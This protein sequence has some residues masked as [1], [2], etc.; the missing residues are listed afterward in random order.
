[1]V[2]KPSEWTYNNMLSKLGDPAYHDPKE[3]DQSFLQA[4]WRYKNFGLPFKYNLNIIMYEHH[5]AA[6]DHLWMIASVVHYTVRKP[7]YE[8]SKDGHCT[9]WGC[10]EWMPLT[11]SL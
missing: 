8:W 9:P 1:M 5:R 3:G 6:W 10:Q 7:V 4:Y 2:L 11:V